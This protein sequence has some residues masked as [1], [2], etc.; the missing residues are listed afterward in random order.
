MDPDKTL[1]CSEFDEEP[2]LDQNEMDNIF[3]SL[4]YEFQDCDGPPSECS[5][6]WKRQVWR[7]THVLRAFGIG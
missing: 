3:K 4:R 5:L 6:K 1:I 7:E 2:Q